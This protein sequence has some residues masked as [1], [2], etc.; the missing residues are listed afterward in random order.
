MGSIVVA[1]PH[2]GAVIRRK[3]DDDAAIVQRVFDTPADERERLACPLRALSI[4]QWPEGSNSDS[5]VAM[6]CALSNGHLREM[7]APEGLMKPISANFP[8]SSIRHVVMST[9][10]IFNRSA[11]SL[12]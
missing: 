8:L 6:A 10:S 11:P 2:V 9:A 12:G 5:V 3:R 7:G 4:S 1:Q